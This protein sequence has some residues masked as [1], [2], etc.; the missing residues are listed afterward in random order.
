M[1]VGDELAALPVSEISRRTLALYAGASG[2]HNPVHIDFDAAREVGYDDVFAHGMLSMAYLGRLLTDAV[3][4]DRIR[5]LRVRFTP[6]TP[7]HAE[8]VCAGTVVAI[9]EIDGA[10]RAVLDLTVIL[11]DC[12]VTV[13]GDAVVAID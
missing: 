8:P 1:N 7:V 2:D 13:R 6:I 5:S 9:E 3:P 4:Q 12:T 10:K 11:A